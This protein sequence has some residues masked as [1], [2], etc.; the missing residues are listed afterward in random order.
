M[1]GTLDLYTCSNS[2]TSVLKE[3]I[4]FTEF[5]DRFKVEKLDS[6]S[7]FLSEEILKS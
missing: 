5:I 4:D 6:V 1:H 7:F 2:P 3:F